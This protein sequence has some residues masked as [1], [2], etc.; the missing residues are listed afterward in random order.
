MESTLQKTAI[1]LSQLTPSGPGPSKAFQLLVRAI[2]EA[3]TKHEEDRIMKRESAILKEKMASRDTNT[4]SYFNNGDF[5]FSVCY[6]TYI[7]SHVTNVSH[8]GGN[9]KTT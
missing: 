5:V 7:K 2:G 8:K 4:V 9:T 1:A 6:Y 3:K